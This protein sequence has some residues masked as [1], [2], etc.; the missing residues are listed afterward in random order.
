MKTLFLLCALTVPPALIPGP[1]FQPSYTKLFAMLVDYSWRRAE[2]RVS[3]QER[4]TMILIGQDRIIE[5]AL[6]SSGWEILA[7]P[8]YPSSTSLV[9]HLPPISGNLEGVDRIVGDLLTYLIPGGFFV[10][11]GISVEPPMSIESVMGLVMRGFRKTQFT[12]EVNH[13]RF[14]IYQKKSHWLKGAA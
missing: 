11:E 10:V 6:R 3:E 7:P 4:R 12:A 5:M 9:L 13:R 14:G 2:I 8:F 1:E